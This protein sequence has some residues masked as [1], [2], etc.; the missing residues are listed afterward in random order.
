[1]IIVKFSRNDYSNIPVPVA[2]HFTGLFSQDL[3]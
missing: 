1:M 3:P 2:Q